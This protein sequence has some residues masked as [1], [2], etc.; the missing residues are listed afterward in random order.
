MA[1]LWLP[2]VFQWATCHPEVVQKLQWDEERGWA[3]RRLSG[4]PS[5][6]VSLSKIMKNKEKADPHVNDRR[7]TAWKKR[8]DW[9]GCNFGKVLQKTSHGKHL[10]MRHRK[11]IG[12][13]C[14]VYTNRTSLGTQMSFSVSEN[15]HVLEWDMRLFCLGSLCQIKEVL[16][17]HFGTERLNFTF[18]QTEMAHYRQRDTVLWNTVPVIKD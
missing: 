9:N 16:S 18:L 5:S 12:T 8:D 10:I 7:S 14:T 17:A 13:I 1:D 15:T 3:T 11:L 2:Q 4:N 6:L